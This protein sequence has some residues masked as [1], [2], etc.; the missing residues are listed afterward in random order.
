MSFLLDTNIISTYL[1]R[2]ASLAHRFDQHAGRLYV[3]T[4]VLAERYVAAVRHADPSPMLDAVGT[5]IRD[6]VT[7][8]DFDADC[9]LVF[10]EVRAACLSEGVTIPVMDLLIAS[11]ALVHDLTV[12]TH[13]TDHF[14]L[15]PGLRLVDWL[16]P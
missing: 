16:V 10:G 8:L 15:V 2:P 4:V 9:A 12:V 1:K 14:A 11:I 13:N 6:E 3:P 7:V 5:L